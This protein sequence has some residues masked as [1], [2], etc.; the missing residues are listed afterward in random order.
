MW[1]RDRL[2]RSDGRRGRQRPAQYLPSSITPVGDRFQLVYERVRAQYGSLDVTLAWPRL[3]LLLSKDNRD[4]VLAAHGGYVAALSLMSWAA[5]YVVLGAW[6]WPSVVAG[7]IGLVAGYY[8]TR[9]AAGVL[10]DLIEASVDIH[11]KALAEALGVPLRDGRIG[12]AE[13]SAINNIL[14][15][16]AFVP[17]PASTT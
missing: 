1:R 7:V 9:L 15:K 3:W 5:L 6:W 11:Q 2:V 4:T 12:P 17:L 16:R 14:N 8:R 10:A 13:G